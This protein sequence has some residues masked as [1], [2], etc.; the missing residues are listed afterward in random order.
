MPNSTE[1]EIYPLVNVKMPTFMSRI[2]TTSECFNQE[3]IVIFS[4][5]MC[6]F[7]EQLKYHAQLSSIK[8]NS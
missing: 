7:Y 5:F 1:H 8:N 3:N 2:N 6:I 4:V